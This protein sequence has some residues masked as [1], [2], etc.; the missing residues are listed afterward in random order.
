MSSE[1]YKAY[2]DIIAPRLLEVYVE[3][4][5]V[6]TLPPTFREAIILMLLKPDKPT[7]RPD[8]YRPLSSL[9]IDAKILAKVVANHLK[10]VMP[11]LLPDQAGFVLTRSTAHNLRTFFALLYQLQPNIQAAAIFLDATKTFD[12]LKWPFIF[13]LPRPLG[14]P[15]PFV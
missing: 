5:E 6:G 8:S 15:E 13:S 3:D 12:L 7:D 11:L 10:L 1:F 9:N 14:L 2:L 4:L